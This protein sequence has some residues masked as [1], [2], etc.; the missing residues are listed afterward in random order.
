M[1]E[2]P[3]S[4]ALREVPATLALIGIIVAYLGEAKQLIA[5]G[6][7]QNHCATTRTGMPSW[8]GQRG[9]FKFCI[10]G[11]I[12]QACPDYSIRR[13]MRLAIVQSLPIRYRNSHAITAYNDA[14]ERTK[15]DILALFDAAI[16]NVSN[17]NI[18]GP[19]N[20]EQYRLDPSRSRELQSRYNAQ[21]PSARTQTVSS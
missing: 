21:R 16:A 9:A 6:W 15:E 17:G 5:K 14:S 1:A 8:P 13:V 11:A 2:T 10:M 7:C 19:S 20:D 3:P 12:I 18:A 4:V